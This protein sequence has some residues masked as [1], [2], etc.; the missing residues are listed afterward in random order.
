MSLNHV[1]II[2]IVAVIVLI[3]GI[4]M[5]FPVVSAIFFDENAVASSLFFI[6]ITCIA[7][8]YTTVTQ[9]HSTSLKLKAHEGYFIAFACWMVV[10]II[11]SLP[12]YVADCGYK[13]VDCFFESVAGWTTTGCTVLDYDIMPKSLI[14]WKAMCHWLGG[15]GVLILTV[16][17]FPALGAGGQ[18]MV[19]AE[20]AGPT[21]EKS[22]ARIS[23]SAKFFYLIY[24]ILTMIEFVLLSLGGMPAFDALLNT[25]S[26]I[27]TAGISIGS[28]VGIS[29]FSPFIKAVIG[30]FS[31]LSSINFIVLC[32]LLTGKAKDAIKNV[33]FRVFLGILATAAVLIAILLTATGTYSNFAGALGDSMVQVASFGSTSGFAVT[34]YTLWPTACKLIL[35]LLM[36]IG[37][38]SASTSG[39]L[40]VIRVTVWF[41]L[42]I[43]GIYKRIHPHSIKPIM[44]GEGPVSAATASNITVFVLL[45]FAIFI[46]SCVV[47][48]LENFDLE[49]TFSAVLAAFSNAGIGFGDLGGS[50]DFSMFS[51]GGRFYLTLLM[52]AGR[53]EMYPIMIMLSRSFWRPN[54]V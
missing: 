8:G 14:F 38:C 10:C 42:I 41:K 26:T 34:D 1:V 20:F 48:S 3:E 18:K 15:M 36:I 39:S 4:A 52:L 28:G 25:L 2:K 22:N 40:K 32:M 50:G 51:A 31:V 17:V 46:F 45:Y 43:R 53:L 54:R 49:T 7:F 23:K 11:G 21:L 6:A 47:M 29:G 30:V 16:S 9:L 33:E 19:E 5:L 37:G 35:F 27:S 13:Y 24:I 12:F 44:L